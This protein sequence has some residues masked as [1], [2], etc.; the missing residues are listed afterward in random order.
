MP[1]AAE[2]TV[3]RTKNWSWAKEYNVQFSEETA[4]DFFPGLSHGE[5]VL[6]ESTNHDIAFSML[7][8]VDLE[9][10][11]HLA[12]GEVGIGLNLRYALGVETGDT[13]DVSEGQP[14]GDRG[15]R[16]DG[17]L[18][19]RPVLCRV[20]KSVHPDIG[21]EICRISEAVM[22]DLG[23]TPGDRVIIE[24]STEEVSLKAFPLREE[25]RNQKRTQAEQNPDRYPDPVDVLQTDRI[26]GTRVDIPVIYLDSERRNAL[27]LGAQAG[28]SE[29]A[30]LASGVCQ[31]VKVSRNATSVYLRS[32]NSV[33]VPVVVGL[34]ATIF[35]FD[36]WLTP[37]GKL[38]VLALGL[39]FVVLS[40]FY[41]VRKTTLE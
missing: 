19:R 20:R 33:T 2:L 29:D 12:Y 38:A 5:F 10:T 31:P 18:G 9:D 32:L 3:A 21:F 28:S 15:G 1:T 25:I 37:L 13:V 35:A 41:R 30:T 8:K 24:S 6:V 22:D 16:F 17:L 14:D 4:D 36:A 26:A 40:I 34:L 11:G 23:I 39:A 27:E 7:G